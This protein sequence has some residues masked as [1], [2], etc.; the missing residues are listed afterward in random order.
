MNET[1]RASATI[2]D[3]ARLAGVG[4][5]TVSR[6]LNDRPNVDPATRERVLA[7]VRDL[8]YVPSAA[9]RRLSLGRTQTIAVVVPYL[10]RPAVVERLRGIEHALAHAELDMIVFNVE[11]ALRRDH[12]L[13]DLM[14]PTRIDGVILVS[15]APNERELRVIRSAGLP[16]VLVDAHHRS[17][18]RVVVDD[19]GGGRLAGRHLLDLGH[20]RI[21]FVGD[22]LRP[23]L[24]FSSSRLRL[25]GLEQTLRAAGLAI[26]DQLIGLGDHGRQ[27]A[28]ELADQLLL[29]PEPPTAIVAASDTQA[30]GALEAALG[31]GLRVPD[32][33]SIVGYDDI[34]AADYLGLT[35]VHQPLAETGARAVQRLVDL[36]AG[37]SSPSLR[38]V[39]EVHLVV[40][41]T[42]GR[43]GS[44]P[45]VT[46]AASATG[47]RSRTAE[48][49]EVSS[50][51]T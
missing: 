7:V 38:E 37:V 3:V 18:P 11:T 29:L 24:G 36:I 16:L 9:A 6:V 49:D 41:R 46:A 12:V 5:G 50:S 39:F 33:V 32:D 21:G 14:R 47:R 44:R 13:R 2:G 31:L 34:E 17:V 30:L 27:R 19:V 1:K 42:T 26:P 48:I 10:T 40:R 8:H 4:R 23:P 45:G 22:P 35:T 25:R 43:P 28:R 20:V 51:L 15:I